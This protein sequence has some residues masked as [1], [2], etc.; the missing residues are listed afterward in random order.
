MSL[1]DDYIK[2]A[3][4]I[5]KLVGDSSLV[6][7]DRE[8]LIEI[9]EVS[10]GGEDT[11]FFDERTDTDLRNL[12]RIIYTDAKTTASIPL[13]ADSIVNSK[14]GKLKK[15]ETYEERVRLEGEIRQ[16]IAENELPDDSPSVAKFYEHMGGKHRTYRKVDEEAAELKNQAFR[17]VRYSFLAGATNKPGR[18][19]T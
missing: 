11:G 7:L 3:Q 2:R 5:V 1:K 16:V 19:F 14:Y 15:A 10:Y 17:K 6:D 12:A 13:S 4:R 18:K 9:A 8:A